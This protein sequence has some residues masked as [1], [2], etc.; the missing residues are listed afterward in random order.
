VERQLSWQV[1]VARASVAA[2]PA[3]LRGPGASL[4]DGTLLIGPDYL[5]FE[6]VRKAIGGIGGMGGLGGVGDRLPERVVHLGG[7]VEVHC[8]SLRTP[9]LRLI[10]HGGP[11]A[12]EPGPAMVPLPVR[13]RE[14]VL[15]RLAELGFRTYARRV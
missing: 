13:E 2:H 7:D 4:F 14:A 9:R 1:P 15:A 10:L 5:A 6:A 12:E 11:E 8:P 3:G